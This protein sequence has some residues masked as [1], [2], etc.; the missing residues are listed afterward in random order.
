[1]LP[2]ASPPA[3]TYSTTYCPIATIALLT[4]VQPTFG[5]HTYATH[6]HPSSGLPNSLGILNLNGHRIAKARN[7]N[8]CKPTVFPL[9]AFAELVPEDLLV[10]TNL[11]LR[12]A[13]KAQATTVK[14]VAMGFATSVWKVIIKIKGMLLKYFA[15]FPATSMRAVEKMA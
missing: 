4:Q 6:A 12:L 11:L 7:M 15:G 10:A 9:R 13:C 8:I 5:Y 14:I 3:N 2:L 1:L